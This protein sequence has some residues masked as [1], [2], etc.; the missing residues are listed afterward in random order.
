[1]V[2]SCGMLRRS[3]CCILMAQIKGSRP[4]VVEILPLARSFEDSGSFFNL[5][6]YPRAESRL[7]IEKSHAFSL[8]RPG[9]AWRCQYPVFW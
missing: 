4:V 6:L 2:L 1:M 9:D 8:N 5:E 3:D 7:P